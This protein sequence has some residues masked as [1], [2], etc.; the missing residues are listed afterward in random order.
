MI[1]VVFLFVVVD[2]CF[3]VFEFY[4]SLV[5]ELNVEVVVMFVSVGG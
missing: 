4:V 1:V 5:C 3:G 2:D